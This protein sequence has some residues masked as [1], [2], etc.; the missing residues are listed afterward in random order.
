MIATMNPR[1]DQVARWLSTFVRPGQWTEL[2]ALQVGGRKVDSSFFDGGRLDAMAARALELEAAG[3]RGVYFVP[4]P[5]RPDIAD[6]RR[7]ARDEDVIAR[8][9]LLIDVDPYKFGDDGTRLVGEADKVPC[10]D[11]E[12]EA[13]WAVLDR[14]KGTLDAAGLRGAVVGDSGNGWHLCYPLDLPNDDAARDRV[15]ALLKGLHARCSDDLAYVDT[16]TYNAARIW[17]LYGTLSRKGE[18]GPGRP[19]RHSRLIEG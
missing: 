18:P 14:C 5:L 10:S 1:V 2:R 8:H 11:S 13:V 4:N 9:W 12:R 3:A 7:C 15:K 19:Y 17:K 16:T 6:S